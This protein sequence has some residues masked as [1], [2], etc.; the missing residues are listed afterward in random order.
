MSSA[1]QESF[2]EPRAPATGK[3]DDMR[4]DTDLAAAGQHFAAPRGAHTEGRLEFTRGAGASHA[5][6]G[7]LVPATHRP[8]GLL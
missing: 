7:L 6:P 2:A 1:T 8:V 5:A 3:E 4:N